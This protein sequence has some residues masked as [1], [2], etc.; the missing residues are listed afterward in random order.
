MA[1]DL[2]N[3]V[4]VRGVFGQFWL[5]EVCVC[6]TVNLARVWRPASG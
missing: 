3:K 6:H 5:P 4:F 2:V 1:R